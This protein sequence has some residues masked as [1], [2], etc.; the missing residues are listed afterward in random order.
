MTSDLSAA[1]RDNDEN[2]IDGALDCA[3]FSDGAFRILHDRPIEPGAGW[4]QIGL[5]A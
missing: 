5:N 3:S 4:T 2:D 1:C